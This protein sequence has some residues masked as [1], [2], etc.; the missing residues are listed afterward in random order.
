M[1]L[2]WHFFVLH[3]TTYNNKQSG[4]L[5]SYHVNSVFAIKNVCI[6]IYLFMFSCIALGF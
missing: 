3:A 6:R 1:N 2:D 4:L 5:P